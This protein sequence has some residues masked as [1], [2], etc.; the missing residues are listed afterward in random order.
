[1][2]QPTEKRANAKM[3]FT[4]NNADGIFTNVPPHLLSSKP[5]RGFKIGTVSKEDKLH[6][7]MLL[8]QDRLAKQ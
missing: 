8:A 7:Q 5:N 1:V 3:S 4:V 2:P 6:A